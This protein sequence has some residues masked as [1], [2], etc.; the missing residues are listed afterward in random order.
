MLGDHGFF[1]KC[2]PYEG[3]ANIPF[4]IAASA[5]LKFKPGLV[6]DQLVCLEDILPTLLPLA[7]ANS[8]AGIDGIDLVPALRGEKK[9]IRPWLHCEHATCYSRAQAFHSLTDGHFKYIWRPLDGTDQ[10]FDLDKDP[11]EEHDL[12]KD[13]SSQAELEKWRAL[14][15]HRLA[16]R[17]EGF[18]DGNKLIVGRPYPPL[19]AKKP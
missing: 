9:T 11:R 8:P 1:R 12:A 15:V 16:D 2:E 14:L 4:I 10:L 18:S 17:P 13:S 7:G 19:Q 5:E 3:S 6:S